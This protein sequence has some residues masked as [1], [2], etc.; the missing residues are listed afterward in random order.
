MCF[1]NVSQNATIKIYNITGEL[2]KKIEVTKSP[3][4]WNIFNES[5]ASGIYIYTVNG[6]NRGRS[7]G[8]IGIVK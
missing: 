2:V 5:I 6:G 4:D 8:K 3:Q 1:D 7:V